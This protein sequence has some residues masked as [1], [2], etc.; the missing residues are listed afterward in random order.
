MTSLF[1]RAL[2]DHET[3]EAFLVRCL[4]ITH[5]LL[6][7]NGSRVPLH[8]LCKR[9][10]DAESAVGAAH[11]SSTLSSGRN[12]VPEYRSDAARAIVRDRIIGELIVNDRLDFD[13]H[14]RLGHGGAKPQG[15]QAQTG[16]AAY[17]V[18]GLPASGKSALVSMLSDRLGAMVLDSDF[19][20]RK[21]PELDHAL[22]GASM[23]HDEPN[24]LVFGD[25]SGTPSLF[26]YCTSK[27][28]NVVVSVVGS[29]ESGLKT[30]RQ[31]FIKAGYR[32]H[33][34]VMLLDR[35]EAARRALRRFIQTGRYVP[36]NL[37]FDGHANEPVLNYYKAWTDTVAGRDLQWASLGALST[38]SLPAKVDGYSSDANP[39]ALW[40]RLS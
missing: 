6:L 21:L 15:K 7:D 30:L 23:V 38:G 37:I 29:K 3:I 25:G 26:E 16:S 4:G 34:T 22:A 27:K 5:E 28:L 20:K 11:A 14:I 33:L 36:I 24:M 2:L 9:I 39:A 12:R 32:V 35:V 19:A 17:L 31:S 40:E 18:T 10:R 13:E 1:A 8:E